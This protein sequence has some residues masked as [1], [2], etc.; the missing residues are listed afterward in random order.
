MSLSPVKNRIGVGVESYVFFDAL[1]EDG[2]GDLYA[3]SASGGKVFRVTFSRAHESDPAL[4][5]DGAVL[6]FIRG[7]RSADSVE[8]RVWVMNLLN[9]SEREL[10]AAGPG[11]F[12][13]R[14]AWS[15]D[16]AT[17]YI[18]TS[19]GDFATAAPPYTARFAPAGAAADTAFSAP[20][21]TPVVALA[22]MCEGAAGVCARLD[23]GPAQVLSPVG[24]N[25]FRWGSD[26][27]GYFVRDLIEVRPL[28][29]GSTRT[30]RWSGMPES[31]G[32]ASQFPGGPE[33]VTRGEAGGLRPPEN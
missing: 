26:S 14:V 20:L 33:P 6:A 29:G 28:G 30:L 15:S 24:R 18:R 23:S 25:P 3:G 32:T 10:P 22:G 4:S 5:P 1:G 13:Q 19:V 17:L 31:P 12:P 9:G 21:G 7:P 27:V 11:A 2:Q 16:G 8:H